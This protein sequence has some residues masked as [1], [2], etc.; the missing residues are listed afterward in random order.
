MKC[1]M[2]TRLVLLFCCCSLYAFQCHYGG[3]DRLSTSHSLRNQNID[4]DRPNEPSKCY[5]KYLMPDQYKYVTMDSIAM[6]TGTDS[7]SILFAE[8]VIQE[9]LKGTK[10]VKKKADRN[11]LSADPNDCLVWCLEENNLEE[12]TI[13]YLSDTS[14]TDEWEYQDFT[15]DVISK[16]GGYMKWQEVICKKDV[17]QYFYTDLK[18][19]LR[20]RGYALDAEVNDFSP[21][22]KKSL[23][24]FQED[25]GMPIGQLDLSTLHALDLY[26]Y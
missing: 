17:D 26:E 19:A 2:I 6:Y 9:E 1:N 20:L 21:M 8:R 5:A 18:N 13:K 4:N 11:C 15:S 23:R 12:V 7:S 24:K 25:N 3:P 14:Q 22:H 16:S 10:C